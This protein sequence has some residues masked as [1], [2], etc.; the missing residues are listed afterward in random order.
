MRL[1]CTFPQVSF[2]INSKDVDAQDANA[3]KDFE[4][5]VEP[6][7]NFKLSPVSLAR[8]TII[9]GETNIAVVPVKA[10]QEG[11][12]VTYWFRVAPKFIANSKFSWG[13]NGYAEVKDAEGNTT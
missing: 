8:L 1:P 12:K 7:E 3:L 11:R 2:A 4:F 13:A 5:T 6:K 9:D 10:N